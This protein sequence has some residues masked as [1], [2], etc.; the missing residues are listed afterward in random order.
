MHPAR[1]ETKNAAVMKR[2]SE[3]NMVNLLL[4]GDEI[5]IVMLE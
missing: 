2:T 3:R 4:V 1:E 5:M